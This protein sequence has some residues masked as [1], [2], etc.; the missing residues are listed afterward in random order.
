MRTISTSLEKV[1]DHVNT[2]SATHYD[3]MVPVHE[4]QFDH[5]NRI[6]ISG[7]PVEIAP[8]AQMLF[9]NRLRI[10][11]SYLSR[12]PQELQAENLNFWL[13]EEA[14]R[15]EILFCRFDGNRL[16]A[17][18]TERY[19]PMDNMSLLS[20]MLCHGFDPGAKVQYGFDDSIFVLK[21][22][23]YAKTFGLRGDD[24]IVPGI[25]FAN[26]EVG[27]MAFSIEA[28]FLRLVCTNGLISETKE[29]VRF[30]HTSY[31]AIE[32]F[33]DIIGN[34]V[35]ALDSKRSQLAF[36]MESRVENPDG[37]ITAF[38]QKFGLTQDETK[39]VQQAFYLEPG[40]TMFN[41]IN[42]FTRAAQNHT[43]EPADAYKLEKT[44]G[45]ILGMIK[46]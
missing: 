3:E 30:R 40:Y 18:F 28:Y 25:S 13:K 8:T 19:K 26:S 46:P 5:L 33:Q 39:L 35:T 44:A 11:Y 34:V 45:T 20:E 6:W 7:K 10:P 22:P 9:S 27:L 36:S 4:M 14:R 2:V 38:G 12:C 24:E 41:V 37:S 29:N 16:R 1:I 21:V 17:V 15:R 31:K 32:N 43:L 23:D 42:A